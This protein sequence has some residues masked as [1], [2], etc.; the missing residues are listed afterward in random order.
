MKIKNIHVLFSFGDWRSICTEKDKSLP[1]QMRNME[2]VNAEAEANY[3][4]SNSK[5]PAERLLPII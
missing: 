4:I 3:R 5:F 2:I 1:K